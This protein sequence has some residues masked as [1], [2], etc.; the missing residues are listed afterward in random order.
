MP[1]TSIGVQRPLSLVNVNLHG[2]PGFIFVLCP[3]ASKSVTHGINTANNLYKSTR[4]GSWQELCAQSNKHPLAGIACRA[5]HRQEKSKPTCAV[6]KDLPY[7][8][9]R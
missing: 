9:A 1:T 7:T 6:E 2:R 3:C 5:L 8:C 4:T